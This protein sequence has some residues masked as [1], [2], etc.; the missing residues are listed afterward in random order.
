[1]NNP[2]IQKLLHP[3]I[4]V[5]TS[6]GR[7]SQAMQRAEQLARRLAVPLVPREGSLGAM[8][9]HYGVAGI[10][11]VMPQRPVYVEPAT[12]LE[13]FFHPSMAKVR[14]HN[15]RRGTGDPLVTAA[16]LQS[17]DSVLDCTVGRAADAIVCSHV[18]GEQGR[19]VGLERSRI[20]AEL[21]ID[22]IT[23]Y[24]DPSGPLTCALRRITV[25]WADHCAF[26]GECAAGSFE[27]VYFDPIFHA[28]VEASSAM[29]PLRLLADASPLSP[30]ALE[31][32]MRV[33]RRCVVVKQRTGTPLWHELPPTRVIGGEKST[34]EYGVFEKSFC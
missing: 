26:M 17:D 7:T 27:V 5:T 31:E 20:L 30:G 29:Q 34:V 2:D 4:V 3:S 21:T 33:A 19:V 15:L 9:D 18:V 32:A 8:C 24:I 6:R 12:G 28:P 10:I 22:G 13:Y 1:M 25:H 23:H 16:G 11:V 14:L